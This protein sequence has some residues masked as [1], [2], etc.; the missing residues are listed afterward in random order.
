MGRG[1]AQG[2]FGFEKLASLA[3]RGELVPSS[4]YKQATEEKPGLL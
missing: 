3:G 1:P 4:E 2:G